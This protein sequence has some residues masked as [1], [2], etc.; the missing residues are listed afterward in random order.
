MR[1]ICILTAHCCLFLLS[2]NALSK[3]VREPAFED[4]PVRKVFKGKPARPDVSRGMARRFRT[5]IRR[6]AQD[7]PDFAGHY[8]VV[9]WG[10][11]TCCSQFAIV[12]AQYGKVYFPFSHIECANTPDGMG[13]DWQ[14]KIDSDLFILIGARNGKRGGKY[15]YRW[16]NN[17]FS[18]VRAIRY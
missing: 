9:D 14:Y 1:L 8:T 7:G 10:C 2:S 6:Q 4:F 5:E 17:K 15:Y 18:L 13:H 16:R 3:Q 11:G 12:D